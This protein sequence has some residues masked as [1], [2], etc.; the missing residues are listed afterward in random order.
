MNWGQ[1]KYVVCYLCLV[2][3]VVTFWSLAQEVAGSHNIFNKNA[4]TEFANSLNS[5]KTFRED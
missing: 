3:C 4:V 5:V 1:F 2:G